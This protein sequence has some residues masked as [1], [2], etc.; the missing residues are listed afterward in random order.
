MGIQCYNILSSFVI[1]FN[2]RIDVLEIEVIIIKYPQMIA[3]IGYTASL[4][5]YLTTIN[6]AFISFEP[7]IAF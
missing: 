2:I 3:P 1:S 5:I 4:L 7:R 6:A